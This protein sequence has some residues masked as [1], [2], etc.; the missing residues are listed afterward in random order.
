MV[1]EG[2]D[3]LGVVWCKLLSNMEY[4]H[5]LVEVLHTLWVRQ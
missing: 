5:A 1:E 3:V 2:T 4:K